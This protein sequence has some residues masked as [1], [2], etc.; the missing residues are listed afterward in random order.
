MGLNC[1]IVSGLLWELRPN[2]CNSIYEKNYLLLFS[3]GQSR[4]LS[5]LQR[6]LWITPRPGPRQDLPRRHS[7]TSGITRPIL[8]SFLTQTSR[9]PSI[10]IGLSILL[11]QLMGLSSSGC[12]LME[13]PPRSYLEAEVAS[14]TGITGS[15]LYHRDWL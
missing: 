13:G 5:P 2:V 3:V 12:L 1:A 7:V 9:F 11:A 8:L 14:D 4:H 15:H 10:T 6:L